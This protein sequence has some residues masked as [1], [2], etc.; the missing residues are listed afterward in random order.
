M[1]NYLQQKKQDYAMKIDSLFN[2]WCWENWTT[3]YKRKKLK[4]STT[5][6]TKKTNS[7]WIKFL[8]KRLEVS[9]TKTN[10]I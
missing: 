6:Y 9:Q 7:K 2:M 8:N 10:I 1:V 3:E 4:H 5:S